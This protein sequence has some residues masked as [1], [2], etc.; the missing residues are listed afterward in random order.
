MASHSLM[1]LVL[2]NLCGTI[3]RESGR[4]GQPQHNDKHGLASL[5]L[6]GWLGFVAPAWLG[7]LGMASLGWLGFA[8]LPALCTPSVCPLCLSSPSV[9]PLSYPLLSIRSVYPRC[10]SA[11][12]T[13]AGW[14]FRS[15]SI[16][17]IEVV[18]TLPRT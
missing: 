18:R 17:V 6:V 4:V 7:W 15:G 1:N 11:V 16:A 8:C 3:E 13:P 12:N 10:S 9:Y 14:V 2:L 5:G